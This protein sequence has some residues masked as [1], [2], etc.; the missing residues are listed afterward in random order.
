MH[1]QVQYKIYDI[2]CINNVSQTTKSAHQAWPAAIGKL[3]KPS[4]TNPM[5]KGADPVVN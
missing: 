4:T 5:I 2:N 3:L 1:E